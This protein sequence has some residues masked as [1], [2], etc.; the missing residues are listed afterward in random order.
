MVT[1]ICRIC[2]KRHAKF[3]VTVK[4]SSTMEKDME[5]CKVCFQKYM[6]LRER[7]LIKAYDD[8]IQQTQKV[9]SND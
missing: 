4:I 7:H 6:K 8:L 1:K 3:P 5:M 2:G 9:H